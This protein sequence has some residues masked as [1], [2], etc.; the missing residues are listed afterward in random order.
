MI[1]FLLYLSGIIPSLW[2]MCKTSLSGDYN[3]DLLVCA[4]LWPITLSIVGV[5]ELKRFSNNHL[6]NKWREKEI[7]K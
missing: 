1:W 3:V 5:L 2:F 6:I 4:I 7:M